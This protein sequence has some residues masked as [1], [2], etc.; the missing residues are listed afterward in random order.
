LTA[1]YGFCSGGYVSLPAVVV[2]TI[3]KDMRYLGTRMGMCFAITSI[4]L[5]V[6]IP[7]GGAFLYSSGSYLGVQI[8]C[9]S[10]LFLSAG[11]LAALRFYQTGFVLRGKT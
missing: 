7:I 10:C 9:G 6:G 4:A 1:L 2:I 11:W 3:T 8:F 5:L